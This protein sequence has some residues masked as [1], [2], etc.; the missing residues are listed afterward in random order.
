MAQRNIAVVEQG[1]EDNNDVE[2]YNSKD[3]ICGGQD[4]VKS[5]CLVPMLYV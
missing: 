4:K 3:I 2:E 1:D 5:G